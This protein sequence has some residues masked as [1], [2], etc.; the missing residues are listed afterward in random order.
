MF[1]CPLDFDFEIRRPFAKS[2]CQNLRAPSNSPKAELLSA[3]IE[4]LLSC[5]ARTAQQRDP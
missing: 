2:A 4:T 3:A 5:I 1:N